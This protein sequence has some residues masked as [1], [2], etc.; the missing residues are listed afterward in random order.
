MKEEGA[1]DDGRGI[2]VVIKQTTFILS[3]LLNVLVSFTEI[4][5][6]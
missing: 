2:G 4:E 1:G 3:I 6:F 5:I